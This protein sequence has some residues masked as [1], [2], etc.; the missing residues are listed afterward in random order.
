MKILCFGNEFLEEDSLAKKISDEIKISGIGF[1]KCNS[2]EEIFDYTDET[3]VIL[4]V[5]ENINDV[6]V[7]KDITEIKKRKLSTLHDFDL[8]F[9][10]QLMEKTGKKIDAK[11]ICI[12]QKG[13]IKKIKTKVEK[14]L[15][16]LR[17]L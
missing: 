9:F 16:E 2:P 1:V 8:G 13:N 7:L 6:I 14:I 15:N 3:F 17:P 4:D 12:P 10:L 5:A 11:I